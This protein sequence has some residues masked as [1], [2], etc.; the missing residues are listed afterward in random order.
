[1]RPFFENARSVVAA[2][3]FDNT[4]LCASAQSTTSAFCV[5]IR[6]TVSGR[7]QAPPRDLSSSSQHLPTTQTATLK[8]KDDGDYLIT[9]A[10]DKVRLAYLTAR[11]ARRLD[12]SHRPARTHEETRTHLRQS[13]DLSNYPLPG[14]A[15][16]LPAAMPT[17]APQTNLPARPHE[18]SP[19]VNASLKER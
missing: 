16:A 18:G 1:M 11:N 4:K 10:A 6:H 9:L 12:H 2:E 7:P 15:A 17:V 8:W 5:L 3:F 19:S 13:N 14:T